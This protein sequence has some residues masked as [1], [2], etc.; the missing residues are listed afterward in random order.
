[1][2][3]KQQVHGQAD[4]QQGL[5]LVEVLVAL[6]ILA[7]MAGVANEVVSRAIDIR[8]AAEQR[9]L[10]QLCADNLLVEWMLREDFPEVGR[11]EG[12]EDYGDQTCFW[13][14]EV[15]GTPLPTMR[16]VDIQVFSSSQR[17]YQLAGMS[18]F[19]GQ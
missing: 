10:G 2:A 15:Q 18:G 19:V 17:S 8:L 1:M 4:K 7:I 14:V 9:A 11:E 12:E 6:F 16:R 13:R 5:T 3:I